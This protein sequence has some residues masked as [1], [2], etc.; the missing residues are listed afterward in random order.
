MQRTAAAAISTAAS[1]LPH[2]H[3]RCIRQPLQA[4]AP[5]SCCHRCLPV[6]SI[7]HVLDVPLP[8]HLCC[9]RTP[10]HEAVCLGSNSMVK[11]LLDAGS[12]PDMG[13]PEEGS[14]LLEVGGAVGLL[15]VGL[16]KCRVST[17]V[18]YAMQGQSIQ[19]GYFCVL[20]GV[21]HSNVRGG[22]RVAGA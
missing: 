12:D 6:Q 21:P 18:A 10:L 14:P 5:H 19:L 22:S 11:M 8:S 16:C 9:C 1:R 3:V 17:A 13:H 2:C 15:G 4:S 7:K 20:H